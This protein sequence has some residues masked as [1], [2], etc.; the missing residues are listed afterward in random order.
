M[1]RLPDYKAFKNNLNST[2]TVRPDDGK[3][4][5]LELIEVKDLR[6]DTGQEQQPFSLI[7]MQKNKDV[8]L[9]QQMHELKHEKL[10]AFQI[11]MVPITPEKDSFIYEVIFN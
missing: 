7:F 3:A 4:I 6:Q 5:D 11:L 8:L 9:P 1:T 10:G 2:F